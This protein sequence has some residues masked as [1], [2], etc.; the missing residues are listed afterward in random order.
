MDDRGNDGGNVFVRQSL[1]VHLRFLAQLIVNPGVRRRNI[2]VDHVQEYYRDL[3]S[4]GKPV[5]QLEHLEGTT[6]NIDG[7]EDAF[8]FHLQSL[9]H[10]GGPIWTEA[11]IKRNFKRV[12]FA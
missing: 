2:E 5:N 1:K 4:I 11:V 7:K 3:R 9:R 12:N 10:Q 6:M 8:R